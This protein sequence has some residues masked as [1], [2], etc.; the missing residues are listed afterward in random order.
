[1]GLSVYDGCGDNPC[2]EKGSVQQGIDEAQKN[3]QLWP[4]WHRRTLNE[5]QKIFLGVS[6]YSDPDLKA[7]SEHRFTHAVVAFTEEEAE[8][9]IKNF[10]QQKHPSWNVLWHVQE[11][12]SRNMSHRA[13]DLIKKDSTIHFLDIPDEYYHVALGQALW[14]E[15]KRETKS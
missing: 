7:M 11:M 14:D 6:W 5:K 12:R 1:M 2:K 8:L 10:C 15:E 3:I 9:L 13:L 4:A